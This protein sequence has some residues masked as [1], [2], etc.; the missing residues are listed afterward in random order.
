MATKL[1]VM[2]RYLTGLLLT[3]SLL[4]CCSG[5]KPYPNTLDKNLHIQTE[6]ESGSIFSKVWAVVDIYRVDEYCQIEYEGTVNLDKPLVEIGI[7][8]DRLSYLV[9]SFS[10]FSFLASSSSTIN[11]DTLLKPRVGY[12]YDIK[13]S[14]IE[15]IYNVVV[16]ETHSHKSTSREIELKDLSTC[17]A[18]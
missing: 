7:P 10:S 16:W 18:L 17:G 11:H 14:Y 3:V 12:N 4:T 6:T 15:N 2:S 8:S 5:I 13:V 1:F 9:F